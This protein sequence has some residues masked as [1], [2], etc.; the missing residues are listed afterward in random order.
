MM[1]ANKVYRVIRTYRLP[2]EVVGADTFM[3]STSRSGVYDNSAGDMYAIW[4]LL[5]GRGYRIEAWLQ[6]GYH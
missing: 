6:P 4:E 1:F 3:L 5:W 2:F